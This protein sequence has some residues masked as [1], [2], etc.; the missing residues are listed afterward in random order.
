MI[1]YYGAIASWFNASLIGHAARA[2]PEW[3]FVLAGRTTGADLSAIEGLANVHLLG[4]LPYAT[5]PGLLHQFDVATIPFQL[6][7][8]ILATN[9]VKS[10]SI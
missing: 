2:H 3:S 7:D 5:L 4:E 8:L 10:M 1:G 9:P 6:N